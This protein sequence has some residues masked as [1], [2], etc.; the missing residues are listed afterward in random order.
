MAH[1]PLP[2]WREGPARSAILAFVEAVTDPGG[3]DFVKPSQRIAT[4]DND[5]TLWCERPLQPQF[6]FAEERLDA[7]VERDPSIARRMPFKAYVERDLDKMKELGKRGLLEVMTAI[8][9]GST[10]EEF[11]E[12]VGEWLARARNPRLG[13]LFTELAYLPQVELLAYL[14]DNGFRNFI[15][16]GGGIDV[17]RGFAEDVYGIPCEQVIGSSQKLRFE[18]RGE[19]GVVVKEA[20]LNSFD[21]REEKPA[22]IALHIGRRPILAFGNSDG[23]LAMMRYALTGEGKRLAL[24]LHHDDEEREFA[25]DRDFALSPLADALDNAEAYG[26]TVVGMKDAWAAVFPEAAGSPRRTRA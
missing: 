26:I 1:D 2:S 22:N 14:R 17:I 25:Y 15:V 3:P 24:L 9:G 18:M 8:H 7:L 4:F 21:D 23:D 20:S 5:G 10:E 11:G 13:R 19:K 16:S 6:Y 12:I